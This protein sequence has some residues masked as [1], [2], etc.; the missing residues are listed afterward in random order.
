[1]SVSE[2]VPPAPRPAQV[3]PGS[4]CCCALVPCL[5]AL[6][7]LASSSRHPWL[8]GR[9]VGPWGGSSTATPPR[10][11]TKEGVVNFLGGCASLIRLRISAGIG[12]LELIAPP[13]VTEEWATR[14]FRFQ[15]SG[16][17]VQYLSVGIKQ[18]PAAAVR[19]GASAREPMVGIM[20]GWTCYLYLVVVGSTTV[21]LG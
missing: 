17:G 5:A 21:L 20:V 1:M 11:A 9:Q 10:S 3:W 14:S 2:S 18:D 4:S 6:S 12:E 8:V 13:R 16:S 15:G 7:L 19:C